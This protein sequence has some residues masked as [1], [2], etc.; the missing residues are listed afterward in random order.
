MILKVVINSTRPEWWSSY[1]L[2]DIYVLHGKGVIKWQVSLAL[3][4][5]IFSAVWTEEVDKKQ[6]TKKSMHYFCKKHFFDTL[7]SLHMRVFNVLHEYWITFIKNE[8]Y[9]FFS[10]IFG[11][12]LVKPREFSLTKL[13]PGSTPTFFVVEMILLIHVGNLKNYINLKKGKSTHSS[14]F[15]TCNKLYFIKVSDE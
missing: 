9:I 15:E 14:M 5:Y 12:R 7:T 3:H 11:V 6:K 4:V 8:R 2:Y 10:S 1:K 13:R